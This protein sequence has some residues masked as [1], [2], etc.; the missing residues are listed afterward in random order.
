MSEINIQFETLDFSISPQI[1]DGI[2]V[3]PDTGTVI[4]EATAVTAYTERVEGGVKL[5]VIDHNGETSGTIYDGAKGD[6][7]DKG[8]A[9]TYDDFTPEQLAALKGEKGD[10]GDKG[11][12]FTYDDFTPEQLASLK[13]EKGDKGDPGEPGSPGAAAG[14]GSVTASIDANTGTPS[15]EVTASGSNTSKNFAFAFHNLKGSAGQQGE[16]G[17]KGDKGDPGTTDYNQLTNKPTIPTLTSQLTNDSGFV[18]QEVYVIEYGYTGSV[19]DVCALVADGKAV[20]A[21]YDSSGIDMLLACIRYGEDFI[22]FGSAINGVAYWAEFDSEG[23]EFTDYVYAPLNSPMFQGNPTAPTPTAGDN[24]KKLATTAFVQ[25]AL[26]TK[27][28]DLTNDSGFITL[29][30]LP[31]YNGGVS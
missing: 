11:D 30:D 10:K 5:T 23:W 12:A 22:Q 18:T 17:D 28:S 29:A 7:G 9:F 3:T 20:F 27:V 13:G 19:E 6:K 4:V 14:F 15:V 26:P 21:H 2:S 31:I 24:S 25:A 8:D 1:D 16:K